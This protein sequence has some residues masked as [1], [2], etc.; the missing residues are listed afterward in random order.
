[1]N[2]DVKKYLVSVAIIG[3]YE[4]INKIIRNIYEDFSLVFYKTLV[5]TIIDK[6]SI[7]LD[8]IKEEECD[9]DPSI[10]K[11]ISYF[12]VSSTIQTKE[13]KK[14]LNKLVDDEYAINSFV[15]RWS[16]H[17]VKVMFGVKELFF[18]D[19]QYRDILNVKNHL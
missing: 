10:K 17:K 16:R 3:D 19:E 8:Y 6:E 11:Y 12:V 18:H 1:M 13:P 15:T 4:S 5:K 2:K 7:Q 14:I 9:Y